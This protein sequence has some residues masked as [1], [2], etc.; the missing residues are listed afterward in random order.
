[1]TSPI[2]CAMYAN[3]SYNGNCATNAALRAFYAQSP[4]VTYIFYAVIAIAIA[5][6]A[7]YGSRVFWEYPWGRFFY[8]KKGVKAV[9]RFSG[10]SGMLGMLT[11]Y[12]PNVFLFASSGKRKDVIRR[13]IPAVPGAITHLRQEDGGDSFALIDGDIGMPV[14]PELEEWAEANLSE[15]AETQ[16]WTQFALKMKYAM[17]VDAGKQA[18]LFPEIEWGKVPMLVPAV[19]EAHP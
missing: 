19:P 4:T 10:E 8:H 17:A 3:G 12:V 18:A 14:T 7:M 9:M 5:G 15:L 6:V 13:L 1:M 11:E 16:S 2:V